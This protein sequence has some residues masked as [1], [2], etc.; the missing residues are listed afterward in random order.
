M[1]PT[2]GLCLSLCLWLSLAGHA[3]AHLG[4]TKYLRVELVPAGAEL[5]L[6]VEAVD[7]GYELGL[8]DAERITPEQLLADR[9]ALARW[10]T[11]ALTLRG[12][13]GAC[14]GDAELVG[15][16]SLEGTL[17]G[18]PGVRLIVRYACPAPATELTLRDDSVFDGDPQHEAIVRIGDRPAILRAGSRETSL[19]DAPASSTASLFVLEGAL[20]LVTGYDHVLFLLSLL[21]VA[22]ERAAREGTRRA[23]REIA[24]VVTGFTLGH[25]VTLVASALGVVSLPSRLVES[26]IALSIVIVAVWNVARP[27]ARQGLAWVAAAFGL[28][29]GFGF[30]SVLGELLLPAG[31]QVLALLAFNVGIELAQLGIVLVVITPLAWAARRAWY[32]PLVLRGGSVLVGLVASVWLIER[33]LAL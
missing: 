10:A 30:S 21:V 16:V 17:R 14:I 20:H 23:I 27:E 29:H 9:D 32:R 6:D 19:G 11:R 4:S 5:T 8:P 3:R 12:S 31:E 18:R 2:H 15:P 22:G 28:V 33:S 13:G 26:A 7:V 24:L 25:S 1:R